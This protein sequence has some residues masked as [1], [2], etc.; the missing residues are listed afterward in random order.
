MGY[1]YGAA[2]GA[3]AAFPEKR[4]VHFTGDAS[5]H[6]NLNEACTAVSEEMPIITVILNNQVLGMVY[7]WQTAFYGRRYSSTTPE[8]KTDFVKVIEGFGGKGFHVDTEEGF[9]E[10]F[11]QALQEK[12]PV[13]ICCDIDREIKVLPMIPNGGTVD[14]MILE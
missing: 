6:M 3:Q 8:R 7:Q 9:K 11:K 1:G 14:D 10:A 5:F 2:I 13:W 12:G 4:V